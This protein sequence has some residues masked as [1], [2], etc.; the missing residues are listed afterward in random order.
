LVLA[1]FFV[2]GYSRLQVGHLISQ[3]LNFILVSLLRGNALVTTCLKFLVLLI[4]VSN[5]L[6][7]LSDLVFELLDL[8]TRLRCQSL[9]L[10]FERGFLGHCFINFSS[11]SFNILGMLVLFR[12]ALVFTTFAGFVFS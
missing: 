2:V 3:I 10:F 12:H 9:D 1:L 8:V 7:L 6:V 4:F 5:D 11:E